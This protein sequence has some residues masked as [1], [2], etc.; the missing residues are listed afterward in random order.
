FKERV[1]MTGFVNEEKLEELKETFM[2]GVM[3]GSNWYGSPL[4]LFEYAQA[5]IPI[6]APDA[7]TI[8][9]LFTSNDILF[10]ENKNPLKSLQI[11]L[12]KLLAD[13]ELRNKLSANAGDKMKTVYSKSNQI[14]TFILLI[15]KILNSEN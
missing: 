15:E 7:P 10:I 13:E 4:K 12:L 14:S 5:G 2:I 6:I 11:N 3:P 9:D 1:E 8:K